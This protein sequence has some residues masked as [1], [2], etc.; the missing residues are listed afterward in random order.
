[1]RPSKESLIRPRGIC[2]ERNKYGKHRTAGAQRLA[3]F[4]AVRDLKD[5]LLN[6]NLT[7]EQKILA[8]ASSAKADPQLR[9]I[10]KSAGMVD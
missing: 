10:F 4:K 6:K 2:F 8:L 9:S 1:M 3:K 7:K 5:A